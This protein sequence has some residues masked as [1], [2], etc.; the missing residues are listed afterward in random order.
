MQSKIKGS[1]ISHKPIHNVI[2]NIWVC[3]LSLRP[4]NSATLKTQGGIW[5]LLDLQLGGHESFYYSVES[6][7]ALMMS[8][9]TEVLT[10]RI[11]CCL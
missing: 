7:L 2:L 6:A 4:G 8:I 3:T 10:N 11:D 5:V 9:K 1:G